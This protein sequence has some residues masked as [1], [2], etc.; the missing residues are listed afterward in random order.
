MPSDPFNRDRFLNPEQFLSE[1]LRKSAQ[2]SFREKSEN[3]PVLYRALVVAVDVEG[4]LLENPAGSGNI[5]HEINGK[6]ID[7]SANVG[8]K[9]P[10]N[11]IKARL[12]TD[13]LDQ[14]VTDDELRVFWPLMPDHIAVPIKPGEYAYVMF[15]DEQMDHGLWIGKVSG[16]IGVNVSPGSKTL[17]DPGSQALSNKF[18]DTAGLNQNDRKFDNDEAATR[19]KSDGKLSGLFE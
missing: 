17:K 8:P 3:V 10:R 16:H 19:S 12:I 13:G 15:E 14:F 11:S 5:S 1:V 18:S 2:G 6:T 9:N 7:V 4:G